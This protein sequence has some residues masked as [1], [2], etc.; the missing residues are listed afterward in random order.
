MGIFD[1]YIFK[2]LLTSTIFISVTLAVVI[3]LTQSLR[4]LELVIESGASGGAFWILTLLAMPRFFEIIVPLALMAST[5]FVYNRMTGDSELIVIRA[6]GAAPGA[7]ARP[8]LILAT[9]TTLFLMVITLWASPAALSSMNQMRQIIKAQFSTL[10]FREGVFN[11]AG[12]GLM[13]YIRARDQAGTMY[14][15]MIHDGRN[16][17]APPSTI[18]ARSGTLALTDH[19]YQVLVSEGSRQEYDQKTKTLRR[20][21]FNRYSIDLPDSDPVRQRW[22]KPDERSLFS[23]LNPDRKNERDMES[24]RDFKVEIHRRIVSPL[25]AIVFTLIAA[26]ALLV[27]PMDRRGQGRRIAFVIGCAIII[28]GLHIAAYNLARQSDFGL[29]LMYGLMIGPFALCVFIL[30]GAGEKLRRQILYGTKPENE[31]AG[32]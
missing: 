26:A 23:L 19:G 15:I 13:V 27:G 25:L 31:G 21:D 11:Q 14:G 12:Q 29:L 6:T 3:F 4:F 7:L 18:I 8:A 9:I 16:K 10:M 30:S 1:R 32:S 20:L 28:Q 5:L 2:N 17:D 24:I 22:R